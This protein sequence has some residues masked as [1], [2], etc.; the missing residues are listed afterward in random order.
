MLKTN[1]TALTLLSKKTFNDEKL[2]TPETPFEIL[3]DIENAA[4]KRG[5]KD[6]QKDVD[7][8]QR[9]KDISECRFNYEKS[10]KKQ[11]PY[12]QKLM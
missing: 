4:Y 10:E 6:K 1:P 11:K 7:I 2:F 5:S 3:R 9:E 12:E 8:L